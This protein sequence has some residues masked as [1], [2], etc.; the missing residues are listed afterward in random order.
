MTNEQK[1]HYEIFGFLVLRQILSLD[2][3]RRN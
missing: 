1:S 3:M 2:L